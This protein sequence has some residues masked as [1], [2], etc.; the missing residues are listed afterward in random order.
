M[1]KDLVGIVVETLEE[2]ANEDDGQYGLIPSYYL[3]YKILE[4]HASELVSCG[5]NPLTF[6]YKVL[7]KE[8]WRLLGTNKNPPFFMDWWSDQDDPGEG[9]CMFQ[10]VNC[11]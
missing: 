3:D 6:N 1:S 11:V 9:Y 2:I 5:F 8:L 10:I 7:E 4:S